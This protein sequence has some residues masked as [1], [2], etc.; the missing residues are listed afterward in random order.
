MA[1]FGLSSGVVISGGVFAFIAMI[2]IVPRMAQ[3]TKTV[4]RIPLYEDIIVIG[5]ILGTVLTF[6]NINIGNFEILLPIFSFLTGI[7]VGILAIALAE[8]LNVMPVF[9]R[10]LRILKGIWAFILA[11]ALGKMAG[12]FISLF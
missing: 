12:V 7:F 5:G 10:R 3:K 8:V 2:G 9:R 6:I 11:M 4:S 1:F